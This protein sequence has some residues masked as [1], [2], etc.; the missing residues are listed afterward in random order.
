MTF[1]FYLFTTEDQ[2]NLHRCHS[3]PQFSFTAPTFVPQTS[4]AFTFHPDTFL[5][6]H[7]LTSQPS[8]VSLILFPKKA[9]G[10]CADPEPG[11]NIFLHVGFEFV[12]Q[13]H[14]FLFLSLHWEELY[15]AGGLVDIEAHGGG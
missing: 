2:F 10:I 7:Y 14:L 4:Q 12:N 6:L 8:A 5:N 15:D 9:E 1:M 13:P 11:E 3:L